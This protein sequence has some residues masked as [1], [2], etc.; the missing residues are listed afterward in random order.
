MLCI[1]V[2][3]AN[4]QA[5]SFPF[6]QGWG[7]VPVAPNLY[8]DWSAAEQDDAQSSGLRIQDEDMLSYNKGGG[9][10]F[11][12]ETDY[13]QMENRFLSWLSNTGGA[14]NKTIEPVF[15]KIMVVPTAGLMI[16]WMQTGSIS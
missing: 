10:G 16:I 7:A 15:E 14:G 9:D 11:I 6:G 4:D 13:Y 5:N 8:N 12:Q 1:L 2:Y 3:V